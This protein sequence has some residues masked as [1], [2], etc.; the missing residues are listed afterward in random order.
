MYHQGEGVK[1]NDQEAFKWFI[2]SAKQG[3]AV[4]QHNLSLM[5]D[6]GEGIEQNYT[7]AFKWTVEAAKQG[8]ADAQNNLGVMY[9]KMGNLK[10]AE[11]WFKLACQQSN[12]VACDNLANIYK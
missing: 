1:R 4:A 10:K 8:Y 12:Q 9:A 6:K 7:E 5:Y 2:A 11:K 3:N